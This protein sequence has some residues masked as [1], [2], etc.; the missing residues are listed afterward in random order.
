MSLE[1]PEQGD[2]I[3]LQNFEKAPYSG[4][5]MSYVN[6]AFFNPKDYK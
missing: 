6:K 2:D 3:N 5:I 4:P 1:L